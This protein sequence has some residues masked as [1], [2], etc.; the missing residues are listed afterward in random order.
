LGV[1]EVRDLGGDLTQIEAW[2]ARI[3]DGTLTGPNIMRV[4]PILNGKSFNRYQFVPGSAEATRGAVRLLAFLG[5]DEI[6]VH[7]R[8]P[9]DWYFAALEESKKLNFRLVGHIPM[10]VTPEEASNSG[11]YMIEHTQTLF[12][13]T[14]AAHLA[15]AQVPGAIREWLATKQPDELFAT[16]VKNGTWVDPTI[17]AYA[18]MPALYD[19]SADLDPLYRYTAASQRKEWAAQIKQHP[20]SADEINNTRDLANALVDAT[21]RMIKDHVRLVAGTDAAGPRL[22]AFSL[23]YELAAL[24]R[25]GMTPLEA[26]QTATLNPAVAFG[27]TSDLGSIEAGK[28]ADLVLLDANPLDRIENTQRIQAVIQRGKLYRRPDLDRLLAAAEQLAANN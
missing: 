2:K 6:K 14:F 24:V 23:H 26:L 12:E 22:V 18:E 10:E 4:G 20:V 15:D 13:G 16:F 28:F 21:G 7:R 25:A 1:T 5:M 8:M 11:Q 19:P 3:A 27:R 17:A 9:R